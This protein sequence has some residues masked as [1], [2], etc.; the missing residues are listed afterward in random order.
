MKTKKKIYIYI[1]IL[2]TKKKKRSEKI[3]IKWCVG[4]GKETRFLSFS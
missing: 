1:Y 4:A 2:E 3:G